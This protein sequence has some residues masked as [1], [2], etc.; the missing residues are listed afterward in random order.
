[1]V[2]TRKMDATATTNTTA[3]VLNLFFPAKG[4]VVCAMALLA[5]SDACAATAAGVAEE[6][7]GAGMFKGFEVRRDI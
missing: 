5:T 1:M 2:R 7:E 4:D 3:T 6:G